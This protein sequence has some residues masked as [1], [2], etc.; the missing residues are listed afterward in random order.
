[1]TLQGRCSGA[2]GESLC[3]KVTGRHKRGFLGGGGMI[4]CIGHLA[5]L[6]HGCSGGG[7]YP[8]R[9]N[10]IGGSGVDPVGIGSVIVLLADEV[11][12]SVCLVLGLL[13]NEEEDPADVP[14]T[15]VERERDGVGCVQVSIGDMLG[16]TAEVVVTLKVI[17]VLWEVRDERTVE[18]GDADVLEAVNVEV[19]VVVMVKKPGSRPCGGVVKFACFDAAAWCF[20]GSNPGRKHGTA[21]LAML[22]W[23]PTCHN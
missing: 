8:G 7:H 20:A 14:G 5:C 11:V 21:H 9:G 12:P 10:S 15:H 1:M 19:N 2:S 22:R 4:G 23:H 17:S 18:V 3:T 6:S 13:G 16:V